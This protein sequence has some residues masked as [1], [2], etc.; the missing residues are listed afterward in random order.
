M[1]P[2]GPTGYPTMI[3]LGAWV[4][5]QWISSGLWM[6]S[7]TSSGVGEVRMMICPTASNTTAFSSP[8]TLPTWVATP[9][10]PIRRTTP[11]LDGNYPAIFILRTSKFHCNWAKILM[12]LFKVSTFSG[13]LGHGRGLVMI[14]YLP[15]IIKSLHLPTT[16]KKNVANLYHKLRFSF[17]KESVFPGIKDAPLICPGRVSGEKNMSGASHPWFMDRNHLY[18]LLPTVSNTYGIYSL[19][20]LTV[21]Q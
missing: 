18:S 12:G 13:I 20:V 2:D 14:H 19:P 6:A 1:V 15:M 17:R 3:Y 10:L 7:V 9:C 8:A 16:Y 5:W 21:W 4:P 11:I